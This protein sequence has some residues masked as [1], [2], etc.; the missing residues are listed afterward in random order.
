MQKIKRKYH[1]MREFMFMVPVFFLGCFLF[2]YKLNLIPSGLYIDE[3]YPGYNSYSLLKT[4]NDE[5]GKFLP[6]VLRFCASYNPPL[7]TYLSILPIG[8]F[9]LNVFS[10]RFTAALSGLLGGLVVYQIIKR[11][12]IIKLI[13]SPYIGF[14]LFII[15]PWIILHSRMGYEV[16]LGYL[17]FS[18]GVYYCWLGLG[19][20]KKIIVGFI[21][22]S[23]STYAAY[24]ERLLVPI[25]IVVYL[26]LF[27]DILL[28]GKTV[29]WIKKALFLSFITQIPNIY[30]LTTPV[31]FLKSY[32]FAGESLL[33]QKAKIAE[34]LPD[35]L[36]SPLA[37]IRETLSQYIEYFSPRS[38]FFLPD[39]D[40]Q[41]SIPELS[42]FYVWMVIPYFVGLFYALRNLHKPF[43]KYILVLLLISPLPASL[44]KDPFASHRAIPML[45]PLVVIMTIGIEELI[46]KIKVQI[47]LPVFLLSIAG[48]LLLLW[49]SYFVFLPKERARVWGYGLSQLSSEIRNNPG[50]HYLIDQSRT[51]PVYINLAFFLAYPPEDFQKRVDQNLKKSY[52]LGPE[53]NSRY[54]FSNLETRN[55]NWEK[56][57]YQ[58]QILV[59]DELAI[60]KDQAEEH[61]LKKT[62][63]IKDPM[64]EIVFVGY[65]T[66]PEL[67]CMSEPEN[68]YCR[69]L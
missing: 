57:I 45:L 20:P 10:V 41:R 67:K 27:R 11:S 6:V 3:A 42:V 16:S 65:Q 58:R 34:F 23:L 39:S 68:I 33:A 1:M 21:F 31:F 14:L 40:L 53:F 48:S 9:G 8:I 18:L 47:W 5:Y 17:L 37:I 30:V 38:L 26:I 25:F 19:L 12:G 35:F 56:D 15:S 60:S 66:D 54:S 4:G 22:L 49:R 46:K 61:F 51:K 62:F 64:G 32:L 52:Y 29:I 69:E 59:G 63:E 2:F 43:M 50:I 55:I 36:A 28:R 7:Y 24:P 44:T 13:Y